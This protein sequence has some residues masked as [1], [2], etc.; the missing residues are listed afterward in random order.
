MEPGEDEAW[1]RS[2]GAYFEQRS[3]QCRGRLLKGVGRARF[4]WI[5]HAVDH[6]GRS[7][8]A[9]I[10]IKISGPLPTFRE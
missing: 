4:M 3:L 2:F 8:V 10:A 7:R 1:E 6:F 9:L 5:W